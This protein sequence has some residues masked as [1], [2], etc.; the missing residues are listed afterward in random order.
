MAKMRHSEK[1]SYK[2]IAM[3]LTRNRICCYNIAMR[4]KNPSSEHFGRRTVNSNDART[5][6]SIAHILG[7]ESATFI[8]VVS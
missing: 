1:M 5:V 6:T 2:A 8:S 4:F 3:R 7:D